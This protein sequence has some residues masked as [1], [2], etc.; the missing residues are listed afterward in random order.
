MARSIFRGILFFSF[1]FP[2]LSNSQTAEGMKLKNNYAG[3][4]SVGGRSVLS[5]FNDG[6]WGDMGTGAGGQFMLQFSD[7]V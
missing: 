1:L 7:R 4:L 6:Q 3:V 2:S 5:T